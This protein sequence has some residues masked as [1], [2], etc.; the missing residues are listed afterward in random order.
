MKKEFELTHRS[1]A[2]DICGLVD[3]IQNNRD[4]I[5]LMELNS[6]GIRER[7]IALKARKHLDLGPQMSTRISQHLENVQMYDTTKEKDNSAGRNCACQC[8]G[9]GN[10]IAAVTKR[11]KHYNM[12]VR[13]AA[14]EALS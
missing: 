11:L 2:R 6:A 13:Q 1:L 3:D 10:A 5:A 7:L 9:D 14:I 8:N 12:L 4:A